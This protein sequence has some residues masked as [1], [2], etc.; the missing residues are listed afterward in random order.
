M[1]WAVTADKISLY[2]TL[3]GLVEGSTAGVISKDSSNVVELVRQQY[4]AITTSVAV[5]TNSSA[6]CETR[7]TSKCKGGG[8][9]CKNVELGTPVSFTLH[10]TLKECKR[11][12]FVVTPVGMKD[13]M[14]VEVVPM[15]ECPCKAQDDSGDR[16]DR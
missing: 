14:V 8:S 2:N 16:E 10:V 7:V 13:Q 5:K 12:T 15:C 11:E 4:E 9:E 3:T 1:I 6:R